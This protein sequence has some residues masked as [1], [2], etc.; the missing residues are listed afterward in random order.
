MTKQL[1]ETHEG[2]IIEAEKSETLIV[3]PEAQVPAVIQKPPSTAMRDFAEQALMA[4]PETMKLALAD[5]TERRKVFR[6]WLLSQLKEGLHF[7]YPP[8]C[9]AKW[10][11]ANGRELPES[12]ATHTISGKTITPLSQWRPKPSFYAAGADFVCNTLFVT[13]KYKADIDSWRMLSDE[14][15]GTD[16]RGQP[17]APSRITVIRCRLFSKIT[18]QFLGEGLGARRFGQKGGD[19]NN[20]IKMAMKAAKVA[21]VLDTY[22]LRDL[23]TQDEDGRGQP[24]HDNPEPKADAPKAQPRG[25]RVTAAE[26]EALGARWKKT[27]PPEEHKVTFWLAFVKQA[28]GK[29]LWTAE[30]VVKA[31]NW[32]PN[33]VQ[34]VSHYLKENFDA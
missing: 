11:D 6:D 34:M 25:K 29:D 9:Q 10:C 28:S 5:Y 13:A 20:T 26:V 32:T 15:P 33:D 14:T 21:A 8:G 3:E 19:H 31:E 1:F 23:F 16:D 18:K 27:R 17:T 30:T 12:Q 24:P 7:G 22:G 4:D 2:T